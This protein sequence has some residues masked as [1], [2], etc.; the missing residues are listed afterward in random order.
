ML[1][2]ALCHVDDGNNGLDAGAGSGVIGLMMAQKFP[3][4]QVDCVEFDPIA[5]IECE[6]NLQ[7]NPFSD[8]MRAY[9]S[10][11][12]TFSNQTLYDLIVTNPPFYLSTNHSSKKNQLQKHTSPKSLNTWLS[13]CTSML[14]EKG[15]L[16]IIYPAND[17]H[18][19]SQQFQLLKLFPKNYIRILNQHEKEIRV[20]AALRQQPSET[21]ESSLKIRERNG[22]YT[23]AYKILTASFHEKIPI[24]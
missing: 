14:S 20:I 18:Y 13:A 16:W 7:Q 24:R 11:I 5:F 8:R 6:F 1:L 3:A 4:M 12:S 10:D 21:I 17:A 2:G 15:I 19:Y 23:E 22:D 9:C